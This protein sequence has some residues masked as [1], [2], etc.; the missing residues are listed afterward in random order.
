MKVLVTYMSKT[1][2]TKKVADKV[3]NTLTGD[4]AIT[5]LDI[6]KD[7]STFDFIIIAFPIMNMGIPENVNSYVRSMPK[8][9]KIALC[10]THAMSSNNPMLKKLLKTCIDATVNLTLID[11]FHCQGELSKEVASYLKKNQDPKLRAFGE[12]QAGT[13]GYPGGK[14]LND[15]SAF[16]IKLMKE[17]NI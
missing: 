4:K 15:A 3:F 1:G 11:Y 10:M 12:M 16:T 8:G 9:K 2:N 5:K 17:L 14:E 6:T 7:I 13:I